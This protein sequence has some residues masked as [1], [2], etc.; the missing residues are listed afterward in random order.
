MRAAVLGS[1]GAVAIA[2]VDDPAPGPRDLILR[3]T[4]CGVCGSDVKSRALMPA[5]TVMGHELAG[6]VVDAGAEVRPAWATTLGLGETIDPEVEPLGGPYDV[7]VDC[8]GRPGLLEAAC[9][10]AATHG[11]VVIAG[12]CAEPDALTH[13]VPLMKELTIRFAVYYRP[14]EFR[15][16]IDAFD[17]GRIDPSELLTR[18]SALSELDDI[19]TDPRPDD[20]KVVIDPTL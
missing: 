3:V 8:V 5:G 9:G 12:V 11:R 14:A 18:T 4:G 7:V 2:D 20:V 16:V 1:D 15:A 19:L 17:D 10:S 13:F 6:T